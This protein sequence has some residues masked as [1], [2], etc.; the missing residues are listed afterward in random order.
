LTQVIAGRLDFATLG[1][2]LAGNLSGRP[3]ARGTS[4]RKHV[5]ELDAGY[6]QDTFRRNSRLTLNL[7]LRWELLRSIGEKNNLLST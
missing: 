1:D 3:R 5:P 7:G 6:I 2:F 4:N